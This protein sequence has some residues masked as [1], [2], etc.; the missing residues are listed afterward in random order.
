MRRRTVPSGS[1]PSTI[2]IRSAGSVRAH[3]RATGR[4]I[5]P[6]SGMETVPACSVDPPGRAPTREP[7]SLATARSAATRDYECS[8]GTAARSSGVRLAR[9]RS[10][11][12]P[13]REWFTALLK[14]LHQA[15]QL[16]QHAVESAAFRRLPLTS[17]HSAAI[18]VAGAEA[19]SYRGV[20]PACRLPPKRKW[21]CARHLRGAPRRAPDPT[22]R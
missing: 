13:G 12:D 4:Y 20:E 21:S 6:M 1:G 18:N 15:P 17:R 2:R 5:V 16:R 19:L 8:T 22:G 14:S 11:H 9:S 10:P 3:V 7:N